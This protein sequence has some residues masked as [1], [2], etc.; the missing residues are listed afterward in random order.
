MLND[1]T[2][3]SSIDIVRAWLVA[4]ESIGADSLRDAMKDL[5]LQAQ[6][7]AWT[8]ITKPLNSMMGTWLFA[9][10]LPDA[11][12]QTK[13]QGSTKGDAQIG[14]FERQRTYAATYR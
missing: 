10:N 3:A 7:A 14:W 6:Y 4:M 12:H 13:L 5:D 8:A 11:E 9:G 2:D 1:I